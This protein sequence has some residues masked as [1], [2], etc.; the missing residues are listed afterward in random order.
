MA[1]APLT[2]AKAFMFQDLRLNGWLVSWNDRIGIRLAVHQYLKRDGAEVE[3]MGAE[4]GRFSMKICFLGDNWAR[5]YR[6]FIFRIR[7]NPKGQL[8]HPVLGSLP[9]ACEGITESSVTPGTERDC[10]NLTVAFV[11]DNIYD[12]SAATSNAKRAPAEM[13]AKVSTLSATLNSILAAISSVSQAAG[14]IS[15]AAT[16]VTA[17]VG[18]VASAVAAATTDTPDPSTSQQLQT[19]GYATGTMIAALRSSP[20]FATDASRYE[21]ISTCEQIYAACLALADALESS[22]PTIVS[23]TV[24]GDTN[25][26]ALAAALYG[27]DGYG[28]ID[29][30]CTLNRIP[31]PFLITAGTVLRIA[32]PVAPD[33]SSQSAFG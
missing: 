22:K 21:A 27:R 16:L 25:I 24:G 3:P 6:Y 23:Y 11:E 15:A 5:M 4:P 13:A 28:K 9:V 26:A 14:L 1:I 30:L 20:A 19:T 12:A 7:K 8:V 18:F 32:S 2:D 10:I 31:N 17:A 29:E 33:L